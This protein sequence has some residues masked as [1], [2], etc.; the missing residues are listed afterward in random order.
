MDRSVQVIAPMSLKRDWLPWTPAVVA[1]VGVALGTALFGAGMLSGGPARSAGYAT[2]G[3]AL[4][5]SRDQDELSRNHRSLTQLRHSLPPSRPWGN[6]PR[7]LAQVRLA[8]EH[9]AARVG[10]NFGPHTK[11]SV[12]SPFPGSGAAS[13]KDGTVGDQIWIVSLYAASATL[14]TAVVPT[15]RGRLTPT[16]RMRLDALAWQT[17]AFGVGFDFISRRVEATLGRRPS[18]R[19]DTL[20]T[21]SRSRMFP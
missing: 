7:G 4:L 12:R 17:H 5:H 8:V 20:R 1:I 3:A 2:G 19:H 14:E 9:D 11:A 15:V 10:G 6:P 16:H 18:S 21:V 13:R